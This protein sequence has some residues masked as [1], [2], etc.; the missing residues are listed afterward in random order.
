MSRDIQGAS[1]VIAAILLGGCSFAERSPVVGACVRVADGRSFPA[2]PYKELGSGKLIDWEYK[3]E[4]GLTQNVRAENSREFRCT[5]TSTIGAPSP[6]P[7][8]NPREE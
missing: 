8:T 4:N 2:T 1:A 5:A 7:P 3:D 6:T